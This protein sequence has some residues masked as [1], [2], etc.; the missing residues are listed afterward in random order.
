MKKKLIVY[1]ISMIILLCCS[2]NESK[3]SEDYNVPSSS[4]V[5]SYIS[6]VEEQYIENENDFSQMQSY[7]ASIDYDSIRIAFLKK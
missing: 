6:G 1:V 2:C 4:E 5:K 7:F 3:E